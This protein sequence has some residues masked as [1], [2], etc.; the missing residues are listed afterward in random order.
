MF[1]ANILHLY[2]TDVSLSC[3]K[4]L[5]LVI[6]NFFVACTPAWTG[7]LIIYCLVLSSHDRCLNENKGSLN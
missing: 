1:V 3:S 6:Y 2:I 4:C 5:F 7:I